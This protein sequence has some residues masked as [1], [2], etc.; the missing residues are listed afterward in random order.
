MEIISTFQ[1][2]LCEGLSMRKILPTELSKRTGISKS[3]ISYYMSGGAKKA[4]AN[5]IHLIADVL[6]VNEAWLIGYDVS[7]DPLKPPKESDDELDYLVSQLD[8]DQREATVQFIKMFILK[9]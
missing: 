6:R 4:N 1:K 5:N 2:R 8:K 3:L 7:P 9:K